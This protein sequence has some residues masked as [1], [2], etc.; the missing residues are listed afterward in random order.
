[1]NKSTN[2]FWLSET[3]ASLELYLKAVLVLGHRRARNK[4][5]S[6][7]LFGV[8]ACQ[9]RSPFSPTESLPPVSLA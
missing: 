6:G 9:N 3:V 7:L 5:L 8:L 2:I 4:Q 1:M